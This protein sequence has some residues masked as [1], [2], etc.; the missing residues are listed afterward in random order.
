MHERL[1]R[2]TRHLLVAACIALVALWVLA[3]LRFPDTPATAN[4]IPPLLTQLSPRP[5]FTDLASEVARVQS[6]LAGT[7]RR[8]P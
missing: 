5:G 8:A 7:A 2:E 4:A 6:R 3:R 1:S